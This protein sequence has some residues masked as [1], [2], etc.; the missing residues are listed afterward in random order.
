MKTSQLKLDNAHGTFQIRNSSYPREEKCTLNS[1]F[2]S[3][4]QHTHISY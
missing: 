1:I 4:S 3:V 2:L